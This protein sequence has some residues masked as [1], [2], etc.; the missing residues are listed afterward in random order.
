[1]RGV[2]PAEV[3]G[4][5][6]PAAA[7]ADHPRRPGRSRSRAAPVPRRAVR[8]GRPRRRPGSRAAGSAGPAPRAAPAALGRPT[9]GH[10]HRGGRCGHRP[11]DLRRRTTNGPIA[12]RSTG[13]EPKH[14]SASRGSSTIGRPAVLRLVLTTTGRPVRSLEGRQHPGHQRLVGRVHGLHAGGAVDVHDGGDPVAPLGARR[15]G[16]RACRARAAG[17]GRRSRAARSAS[18]IGATGRNCSRPLTS[19]SRSRLRLVPG[20][21]QQRAVTE[22]PRPV[23]AAPLEPGDD[24][25]G[26]QALGGG[27]GDVRRTLVAAPGRR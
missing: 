10:D 14:S 15:R 8:A 6:R 27:L 4:P 20:V 21:G 18:T 3:A 19:L 7:G 23:L 17:R 12:S 9:V 24:A 5:G 2:P 22:R 11:S 13:A 25:V 26:G 16:R 1:M